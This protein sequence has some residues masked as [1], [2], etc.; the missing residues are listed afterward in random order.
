MG[1]A[2]W[3]HDN[4]SQYEEVT[5]AKTLDEGDNG[6]TQVV[7]ATA[8]LTL[9]STV[10]GYTYRI[11]NGGNAVGAVQVSVSPAAV[12]KIMGNGFTSADNKDAINTLATA[13]PGDELCLVGDGVNGWVVQKVKGTW[14][15]E[16]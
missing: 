3:K 4:N 16:A 15:K 7:T 14:A 1:L 2:A 13:E 9:P 10:A 12:D 6:V 11:V 8:V 5:G